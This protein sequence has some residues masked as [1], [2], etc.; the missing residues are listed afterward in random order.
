MEKFFRKVHLELSSYCNLKCPFCG[1]QTHP[2]FKRMNKVL[3][4]KSINNLF[5]DNFV[6]NLERVILCG[7]YGEPT[8]ISAQIF[9][10]IEKIDNR[11]EIWISTNGSTHNKDWWGLLGKEVKDKNI[12][13][14]AGTLEEEEEL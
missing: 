9:Y 13:I 11:C 3:S 12:E 1:R 7:N 8:F 6:E 5:T 2:D 14:E 4:K 10:L